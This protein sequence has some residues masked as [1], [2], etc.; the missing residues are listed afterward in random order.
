MPSHHDD[1]FCRRINLKSSGRSRGSCYDIL[2]K[3]VHHRTSND[4]Q[5]EAMQSLFDA[6]PFMSYDAGSDNPSTDEKQ[7]EDHKAVFYFLLSF[8]GLYSHKWDINHRAILCPSENCNDQYT[9][10]DMHS[11]DSTIF[12]S[13]CEELS[14][15]Y[16]SR[17]HSTQLKI[18]N[19]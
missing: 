16:Q 6:E 4:D 11:T 9:R 5:R 15:L 1:R 12:W 19:E 3:R 13:S 10:E 17:I 8:R 7:G 18:N 2:D 14:E